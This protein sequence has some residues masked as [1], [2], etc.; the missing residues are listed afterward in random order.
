MMLIKPTTSKLPYVLLLIYFFSFLNVRAQE[1][2]KALFLSKCAS[3]HSPF[4]DVTG[5]ALG[6]LEDRHKWA[7]HKELL[8]WVNNPGGYMTTD[9]Y[10]QGLK[11]KFGS[12]M[13][14]FPDLKLGDVDAIVSYIN[15]EIANKKVHYR[16]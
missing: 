1:A 10:T 3:C 4:R 6:G 7:D 9:A 14:G 8:K 11:S 12:M 16:L 15:T 5:P 2:G 13:T